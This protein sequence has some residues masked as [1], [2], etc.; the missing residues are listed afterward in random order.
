M[1]ISFITQFNRL[2]RKP[3][4][5]TDVF[6]SYSEFENYL[7][8][9]PAY[10]GQI[11]SVKDENFNIKVYKVV[12]EDGGYSAVEIGSDLIAEGNFEP[13]FDKNTGFNKDFGNTAGTVTEGNDPRLSDARTPLPH[14]HPHTE[15]TGLGTAAIKNVG[16]DSDQIPVLNSSGK[17]DLSVI[18]ASALTETFVVSSQAAML[19]LTGANTGDVAIRT[20]LSKSF[21]LAAEPYS[22]LTNWKE[23]LSPL[24]EL[25]TEPPPKIIANGETGLSS[26]SAREDHTHEAPVAKVVETGVNVTTTQAVGGLPSGTVLT[27]TETVAD[28]LLR[29]LRPTVL[30]TL[31]LAGSNPAAG[32]VEIG[33][34]ITPTLTPTWNQRDG[35]PIMNYALYQ[36]GVSEVIFKSETAVAHTISAPIQVTAPVTFNAKADY[37]ASQG[38]AAGT[39]NSG[40]VTYTPHRRA[41]SGASNSISVPNTSTLIRALTAGAFNPANNTTLAVTTAVGN[42]C[43]CFA[44]PATL[45]DTTSIVQTGVGNVV[46]SFTKI[47]VPVQGLNGYNAIDYKVYYCIPE[48]SFASAETFTLT[49]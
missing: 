5:M 14:S 34:N 21:I 18:P 12:W 6:D 32:N 15:V 47:T 16:T 22:V 20:D 1:A 10:L 46:A 36:Q 23:L 42:R 35:G 45:R 8:N 2:D 33:A 48:F 25:A 49:I 38:V 31:T 7:H 19:A 24:T 39:A 11:V 17:L 37:S 44:Y 40:N 4:D 28:L 30:P 27:G 9:G 29:I 43:V 41:F 3:L 26:R 13:K